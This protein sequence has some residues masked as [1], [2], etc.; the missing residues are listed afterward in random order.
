MRIEFPFPSSDLHAHN[1]GNWRNKSKPTQAARTLAKFICI[2]MINR[3]EIRPIAGRVLISYAI[4]V[5]D[6]RPRDT[7]NMLQALKPTIDGIV[8]SGLVEGDS[9]QQMTVYDV[10]VE[11]DRKN[12]RVEITLNSTNSNGDFMAK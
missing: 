10:T 8:D 4:F 5:P 3:N 6:N 2:D 11:I 7:C 12:P 1:S 9:W